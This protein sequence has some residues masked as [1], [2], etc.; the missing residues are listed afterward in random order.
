M[1]NVIGQVAR[2]E[3]FKKN[4]KVGMYWGMS[5]YR[6]GLEHPT[7]SSISWCSFLCTPGFVLR[8]KKAYS[9]TAL[10]VSDPAMNRSVIAIRRASS[11]MRNSLLANIMAMWHRMSGDLPVT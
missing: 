5:L 4:I 8:Y 9:R 1:Q 3:Q 7:T 11:A 2:I 10:E 6:G